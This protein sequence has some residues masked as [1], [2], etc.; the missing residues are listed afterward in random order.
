[1]AA[2]QPLHDNSAAALRTAFDAFDLDGSGGIDRSE[3]SVMLRK[4]GFAWQGAHIFEAADT[5]GDGRVDFD[6]FVA[7]FGQAAA[8]A[9]GKIRPGKGKAVPAKGEAASAKAKGKGKDKAAPAKR[10]RK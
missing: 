3:L 9:K 4:L 5:D 7:C 6:E 10:A 2:V 8:A 1:M